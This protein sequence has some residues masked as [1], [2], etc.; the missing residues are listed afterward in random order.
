MVQIAHWLHSLS[1]RVGPDTGVGTVIRMTGLTLFASVLSLFVFPIHRSLLDRF[2]A[3]WSAD[4]ASLAGTKGSQVAVAVVVVGYLATTR[5]WNVVQIRRP[6]LHDT[7]WM[8]L[9][10]AGLDLMAEAIQFVLPLAGLSIEVLSGSGGSGSAVGLGTWPLLWPLVF[11]G[12]YLL[13]ALVEEQF[14]R[15]IVQGRLG[16]RFHPALE[17]VLGAALFALMHGLYGL[18]GGPEFLAT[19]LIVLFGQGLVFC[20]TYER[21]RNLLVVALIHALSWTAVDVPFFGLL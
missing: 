9:G 4:L 6:T 11:L 3:P 16:E 10:A 13:P 1:R 12:L 2:V 18:G 8:V 17:V 21:T 19:Y 15:G 20:L 14:V 7:L 5:R